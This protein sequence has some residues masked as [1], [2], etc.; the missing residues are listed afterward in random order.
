MKI[1]KPTRHIFLILWN[2]ICFFSVTAFLISCCIIL[3]MQV[4][5][6]SM[7]LVYTSEN[8]QFAAKVTFW[9][10]VFLS[11]VFTVIDKVRRVITVD[12]PVKRITDAAG[13]IAD[14]DYSVRIPVTIRTSRSGGLD[15]IAHCYNKMAAEL[16]G[17]E[18]MQADFMHNVSHEMKTPLAVMQNY[19][20]LLSQPNLSEG[21]R[22][23]YADIIGDASH[24][25]SDLITNILRLNRLD[26]HEI[27]PNVEPYNLGDKLAECIVGF[28]QVWEK[29]GIEL[30]TDIAEDIYIDIDP[31]LLALVWNN[32]I[33]NALK[34]TDPGGWVKVEL[35]NAGGAAVVSISDTGCGM[36]HDIGTRIF[37]KFYQGDTSH[38]TEG[39]G[40]G[41][42]LVKRVV[43]I[44]GGDIAVVSA[45]G[46][47][48]TFTVRLEIHSAEETNDRR[49]EE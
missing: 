34:F 35:K 37:E 45:L 9:N 17:N 26:N 33:S 14:G 19:A 18:S 32:L 48:N 5:A 1:N 39:N 38:A 41:L 31:E 21:E 23:R 10:V 43:D 44:V 47:G 46:E 49:A 13:R 11:F 22:L 29:K 6:E 4:M 30:E 25:L 28:E 8:I 27:Y 7:N 20:T 24:R 16:A 42:A 36:S 2:F 12:I 40:L 3:F 15:E